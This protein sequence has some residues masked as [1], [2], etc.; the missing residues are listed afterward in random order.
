M[1]QKSL[2][3]G[4]FMEMLDTFDPLIVLADN[5]PWSKLE[6]YLSKFYSG[7]G[8]PPKPIRL[9]T[10][11]LL[12]KQMENLSDEN[13]VL[14][15][16]RNPYYQ[17]F[18]GSNDYEPKEPCHPTELVKFRNRIGKKGFEYI[19]KLSIQMH[20]DKAEEE[21]I[22]IDSTVQ[23]SSLLLSFFI[24]LEILQKRFSSSISI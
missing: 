7:T 10:G 20:G 21:Q 3:S 11:L 24:L 5:Y 19:F 2:F 23:E 1:I 9:M 8:R 17:Y 4:T 15:Y 14:Q 13:V 6:N 22:I 12:L 18:C 16:K